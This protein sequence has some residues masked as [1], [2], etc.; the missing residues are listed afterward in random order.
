MTGDR[1]FYWQSYRPLF[2][3]SITLHRLGKDLPLPFPVRLETLI[4]FAFLLAVLYPVCWLLEPFTKAVFHL[5]KGPCAVA[6]ALAGAFLLGEV[7]AAG[8]FLPVF[9][10]D[11]LTFLVLPKR[12]RLGSLLRPEKRQKVEK[13]EVWSRRAGEELWF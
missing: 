8:K 13:F 2:R 11:V 5:G 1:R 6:S 10:W 3:F 4:V 12:S 9:V 7:D